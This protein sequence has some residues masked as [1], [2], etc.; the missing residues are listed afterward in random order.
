MSPVSE[1]EQFFFRAMRAGYA[2]SPVKG[3]IVEFPGSKTITFQEGNLLLVDC[4][5]V[6]TNDRSFGN[7]IIFRDD[8]PVWMMHYWGQYDEEAIDLLKRVLVKDYSREHILKASEEFFNCCRGQR[9]FTDTWMTYHNMVNPRSTFEEFSGREEIISN[10]S[11]RVCG[12]HCYHGYTL[13]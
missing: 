5:L 12:W 11:L 10:I 7:T 2:S 8:K 3:T 1:I 9:I 4:W 6:G 13:G